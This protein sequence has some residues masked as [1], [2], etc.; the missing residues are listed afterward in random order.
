MSGTQSADA[1]TGDPVTLGQSNAED[2]ATT[3][4]V[5]AG[6]APTLEL[7]NTG[8]PQLRLGVVP[9][10][11]DGDLAVGDIVNSNEGPVIG[12]D[13]GDGAETALL[14]TPND[15]FSLVPYTFSTDPERILDTRTS[16][17]RKSIVRKSSSTALTSAGK[18]KAKHWIDIAIDPT[19]EGI[20]VSGYFY[21]V[22]VVDPKASGYLAVT[23]T[24][25]TQPSTST[26]NFRTGVDLA[27][28]GFIQASTYNGDFVVRL[29]T[30]QETHLLLDLSGAVVT[31]SAGDDTA[32]ARQ[33]ALDA[34]RHAQSVKITKARA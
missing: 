23:T 31:A 6:A 21:N 2:A 14:V 19:D 22:A 28:G 16:A 27:N 34:A 4:T 9:D 12:V 18:L 7:V 15:L 13:Y 17:G 32:L 5:T 33:K 24:S 8:G 30:T 25:V 29:Y 10:S 3:I 11:F 20:D 26:I 1:A